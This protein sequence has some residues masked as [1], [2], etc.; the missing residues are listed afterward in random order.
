MI[1]LDSHGLAIRRKR[2]G[3]T[4]LVTLVNFSGQ[5]LEKSGSTLSASSWECRAATPLTLVPATVARWAMRT[6]RSG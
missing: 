6:D 4:P 1:R 2:R 5:K 3:V